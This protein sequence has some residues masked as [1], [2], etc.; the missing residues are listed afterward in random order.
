M[1]IQQRAIKI[2][3]GLEHLS[4]EE[5]PRERMIKGAYMPQSPTGTNLRVVFLKSLNRQADPE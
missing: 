5:R 1:R 2:I 4:Y 3:K